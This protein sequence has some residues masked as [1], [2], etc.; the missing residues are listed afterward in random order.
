MKIRQGFVSNSSST[1]FM[2][3]GTTVDIYELITKYEHYY[4]EFLL[5]GGLSKEEIKEMNKEEKEDYVDN[6]PREFVEFIERKENILVYACDE[7]HTVYLGKEASDCP[8]DMTIGDWKQQIRESILPF[9]KNK[10]DWIDACW[11]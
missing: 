5:D 8:D 7:E 1:S 6:A 10:C 3:Y 2:I 9:T 4:D 11:R